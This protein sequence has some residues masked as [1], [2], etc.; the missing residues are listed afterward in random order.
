MSS[1]P[2]LSLDGFLV[3]ATA[4]RVFSSE[5]FSDSLM[6]DLITQGIG[7]SDNFLTA[8]E[9]KTL[10]DYL[11]GKTTTAVEY[12]YGILISVSNR[13][14]ASSNFTLEFSEDLDFNRPFQTP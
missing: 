9:R 5:N 3:T 4:R 14:F 8:K 10:S 13:V 2:V 1:M 6:L 12:I 11:I 7:T